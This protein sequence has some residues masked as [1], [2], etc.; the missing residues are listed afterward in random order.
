MA[1]HVTPSFVRPLLRAYVLPHAGWL[2]L[3][4]VFLAGTTALQLS[5]PLLTRRFIDL[6]R[7]GA[8]AGDLAWTAGAYVASAVAVQVI[9]V[10]DS[11]VAG[12]VA[13]RAT[14]RLR[15][16]LFLHCMRLD[17]PFH[18]EHTPGALIERIDG[19]VTTLQNLFSS[20]LVNLAGNILLLICV[21]AILFAVDW[22]IGLY[23]TLFAALVLTVLHRLR[24]RAVGAWR[25]ERQVSAEL[26]GYLEEVLGATEDI[27]SSGATPY[28][29]R[30]FQRRSRA[31]RRARLRA[32]VVVAV[33]VGMTLAMLEPGVA[34]ALWLAGLLLERHG[35]S[36]GTVYLVFNYAVL[37][38][39]PL[40][41]IGHEVRDLQ[42]AGAGAARIAELLARQPVLD[43]PALPA[44]SLPDH[45]LPVAFERV[46]F[47][48]G[49]GE[50]VL[51]DVRF[52]LPAGEVLGVL[53]PT[54]SGKTT[55]ARLLVRFYDPGRGAVRIGGRDLREVRRES[56]R[57]HV[58]L[59]PQEVQLMNATVRDNLA[60]FDASVPDARILQAVE[61][62]G[63]ASL[64]ARLPGGLDTVL[65]PGG[66]DL[67]AGE[68]Q[69]LALARALL[70]DPGLVVLDEASSRIDP[71][72]ERMLDAAM[73]R[74]L[75]GR[76]AVVIAHRLSTIER[77]DRILVLEHGRVR[78]EGP[79]AALL[80]DGSSRLSELLRAGLEETLA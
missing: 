21:L 69:L 65:A 5:G 56:L 64:M 8:G 30:A 41:H 57:A 66:A 20:F 79:R 60:L 47:A 42:S 67:S 2:A 68:A 10:A 51:R 27:R 11:Y 61:D 14:N 34:G 38:T 49:D 26:F 25:V 80:A 19:D 55:L 17:L 1:S 3:L 18:H 48:Y 74:L 4:G 63:L 45:A 72:T 22:R 44:A 15:D 39:G 12:G 58:A 75:R 78:E 50:P 32:F 37:L 31:L 77:A 46:W 53:G 59:V 13:W 36:L 52:E 70:L 54:G 40:E 33:V 43:E 16:D 7:G 76:T 62:L 29:T 24:R 6:A 9:S 71:A 23:M 28:A 35:V 73:D